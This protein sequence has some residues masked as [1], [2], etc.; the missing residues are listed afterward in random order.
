MRD[1]RGV[2]GEDKR[3]SEAVLAAEVQDAGEE[4]DGILTSDFGDCDTN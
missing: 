2:R 4:L 3:G 1:N